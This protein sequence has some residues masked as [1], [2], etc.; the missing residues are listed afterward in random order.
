MTYISAPQ[1]LIVD[2]HY[3][4]LLQDAMEAM[5][6]KPVAVAWFM[7]ILGVLTRQGGYRDHKGGFPR[8]G[9]IHYIRDVLTP[10]VSPNAGNSTA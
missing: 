6:I 1:L 3:L 10:E 5:F 2:K 8:A 9:F 7:T 4:G